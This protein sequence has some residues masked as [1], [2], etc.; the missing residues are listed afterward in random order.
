MRWV[1]LPRLISA[2]H[3]LFFLKLTYLRKL[4]A[5]VRYAR[6]GQW[7]LKTLT[8][9][10]AERSR[11]SP[12]ADLLSLLKYSLITSS[13]LPRIGF[14]RE[15]AEYAREKVHDFWH[16][17]FYTSAVFYSSMKIKTWEGSTVKTVGAHFS[18]STEPVLIGVGN[19][20]HHL[21]LILFDVEKV[22]E[23]KRII[24]ESL[25]ILIF[26]FSICIMRSPVML[27]NERGGR[28]GEMCGGGGVV[29][30]VCIINNPNQ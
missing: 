4:R 29:E 23:E 14:V 2:R 11:L 3:V 12:C 27:L 15:A 7:Q 9:N 10:T 28:E 21:N 1:R 17:L 6:T 26:R 8:H 25:M 20:L 22:L 19:S 18:A 5:V 30:R 16:E 24:L 13:L